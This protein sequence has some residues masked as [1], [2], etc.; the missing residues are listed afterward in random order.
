MVK[1][2]G[3][4]E[5]V[6]VVDQVMR[7]KPNLGLSNEENTV[8]VN[9]LRQGFQRS[10]DKHEYLIKHGGNDNH[11]AEFD[12]NQKNPPEIY[13]SKVVPFDMPDNKED[14]K[15]GVIYDTNST[16]PGVQKGRWNGEKFERVK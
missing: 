7:I 15:P 9:A 11:K 3:S 12:F 4:R 13:A 5:A 14:L 6:Q 16:Q 10:I 8:I 1:A 2:L